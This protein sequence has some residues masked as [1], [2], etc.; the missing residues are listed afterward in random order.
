MKRFACVDPV[1]DQQGNSLIMYRDVAVLSPIVIIIIII[2]MQE[3]FLGG[4]QTGKERGKK[5]MNNLITVSERRRRKWGNR[6]YTKTIGPST[7]MLGHIR[8]VG[9]LRAS[10][11]FIFLSSSSVSPPFPKRIIKKSSALVT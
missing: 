3:R 6:L 5:K 8:S 9:R 7:Y 2:I 10:F 11:Y 1:T 4:R